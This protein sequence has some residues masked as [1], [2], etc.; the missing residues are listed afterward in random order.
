MSTLGRTTE[1]ARIYLRK[2][3]PSIHH[4]HIM[5]MGSGHFRDHIFFRDYLIA[6]PVKMREH[7]CLKYDLA[8]RFTNDR[9]VH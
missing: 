6:H 8:R 2:G 4:L 7:A 9:D 5:V 3:M 1:P